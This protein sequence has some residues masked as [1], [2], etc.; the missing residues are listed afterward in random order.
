[1]CLDK[2][3]QQES[4]SNLKTNRQPYPPAWPR[5]AFHPL[6]HH[7]ICFFRIHPGYCFACRSKQV[8]TSDFSLM[9]SQHLLHEQGEQRAYL[10]NKIDTHLDLS[11]ERERLRRRLY[12]SLLRERERPIF[13]NPRNGQ[14]CNAAP[15]L[16]T[17]SFTGF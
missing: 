9:P 17:L 10:L 3:H 11:R 5:L 6:Y 7:H 12:R 2:N 4:E 13:L 16:S 8:R 1:V 14:K 15:F